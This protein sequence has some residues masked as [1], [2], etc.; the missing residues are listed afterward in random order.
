MDETCLSYADAAASMV[1]TADNPDLMALAAA[2]IAAVAFEITGKR[3]VPAFDEM[4]LTPRKARSIAY[5]PTN[6]LEIP[7]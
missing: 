4:R 3:L 1:I 7:T 5:A 2:K 6:Q